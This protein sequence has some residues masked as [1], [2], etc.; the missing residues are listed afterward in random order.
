MLT[1]PGHGLA[2][3]GEHLLREQFV[4]DKRPTKH[5]ILSLVSCRFHETPECLVRYLEGEGV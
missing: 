4:E 3:S 1:C 5:L 2:D